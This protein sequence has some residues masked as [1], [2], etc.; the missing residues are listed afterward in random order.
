MRIGQIVMRAVFPLVFLLLTLLGSFDWASAQEPGVNLLLCTRPG[1]SHPVVPEITDGST[2]TNCWVED[3][4][5]G[6]DVWLNAHGRNTGDTTTPGG[7]DVTF[8]LDGQLTAIGSAPASSN[9]FTVLNQGPFTPGFCG[10]HTV[11]AYVDAFHSIAE[12]NENDN[13]WGG[14]FL[15]PARTLL[16]TPTVYSAPPLQNG[17]WEHCP[18][19][20]SLLPN[21]DGFVLGMPTEEWMAVSL[22]TLDAESQYD[23]FL[24]EFNEDSSTLGFTNVLEADG[25]LPGDLVGMVMHKPWFPYITYNV[26]VVNDGGNADYRIQGHLP[27]ILVPDEDFFQEFGSDQDL[28]LWTFSLPPEDQGW[29]NLLLVSDQT[30]PM[31]LS[32]LDPSF[33][34]GNISSHPGG[35]MRTNAWGQ[36]FMNLNITDAEQH[37]ALAFRNTAETSE[38]YQFR[39]KLVDAMP[40]L[41]PDIS[42][43]WDYPI[44]PTNSY[45]A[46]A[47]LLPSTLWGD[48]TTTFL[49]Y[50]QCNSSCVDAGNFGDILALDG[51]P[52]PTILNLG[53][54]AAGC[55]LKYQR[56]TPVK[57]IGGRHTLSLRL[58]NYD[59]IVEIIEADND[60]AAQYCWSP[61]RLPYGNVQTLPAPPLKDG[62]HSLAIPGAEMLDNCSS[63]RLD[64]SNP[65]LGKTNWWRGMAVMPAEGCDVDVDLFERYTNST[66]SF[67]SP[68]TSSE[69]EAGLTDFVLVNMHQES[70]PSVIF[71]A[72]FTRESGSE[73][74]EAEALKS[75]F[76]SGHPVGWFGGWSLVDGDIVQLKEFYLDQGSFAV[77]LDN[78]TGE[79]VLGISIF[80]SSIARHVSLTS[81]DGKIAQSV[82]SGNGE[83]VSFVVDISKAGLFCVAVWKR[84]AAEFHTNITYKLFLYPGLTPVENTPRAKTFL[85]EARPNP[86]NPRTVLPFSQE[87]A[88]RTRIDVYDLHGRL[89]KSLCNEE[90]SPGRHEIM[91]RGVDEK[92]R[93]VSSGVYVVRMETGAVVQSR[94]VTLV[95]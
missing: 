17:G 3:V 55:V 36:V 81:P 72:G 46:G 76:V 94:R 49:N 2:P 9:E 63:L 80:S 31:R 48:S 39:L 92:G 34:L 71:E 88:G 26:G 50:L 68:L 38:T 91:W 21:C 75:Q 45:N 33:E 22:R 78:V 15:W 95:R 7:F 86:F 23:I 24:Y 79:G 43:Y 73:P 25:G 29:K 18:D 41:K 51:V 54:L 44:T 37:A 70:D 53:G 83:D 64:S 11:S 69:N 89:V 56:Q 62:G 42:L 82:A 66:E 13:T 60:Y 85:G 93:T 6:S 67:T 65:S 52:Y 74:F 77:G 14:Q 47:A 40:N 32:H 19:Q 5:W 27:Q 20:G 30:H 58:D 35:G 10:R 4:L 61:T 59:A 87:K 57:I 16:M 1:W 12:T 28:A 90:L 8:Y 84:G